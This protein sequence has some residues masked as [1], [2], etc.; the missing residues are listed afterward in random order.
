MN[1]IIKR[2]K[3]KILWVSIDYRVLMTEQFT[4]LALE[5]SGIV[6]IFAANNHYLD[7][8]YLLS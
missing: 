4:L 1:F 2:L 3:I 7:M 6:F 8:Y 5:L